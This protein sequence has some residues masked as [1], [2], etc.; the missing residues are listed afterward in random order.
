MHIAICDDNV[1]DRKQ[2]ERLL[3][4]ESDSRKHDTGVFYTDSYG[5]GFK[6]LPR[7]MSYDLFFLSPTED[8]PD[9]I[10]FAESLRNQ[11]VTAPIAIV[12]NDNMRDLIPNIEASDDF[13][14]INKPILK[15]DLSALLDKAIDLKENQISTIELRTR[16]TTF[17]VYEDDIMYATSKGQYVNVYLSDGKV[18]EVLDTMSNLYANISMYTHYVS[19]SERSL[20]NFVY[21]EKKTG[22]FVFL[23]NGVRLRCDLIGMREYKVRYEEFKSEF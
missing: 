12:T 22:P 4:R 15:A 7:R 13:L 17:Y 1:A 20:A 19:L 3:G 23:K 14:Y 18:L 16:E 8:E 2:L 11:G 6:I 21:I 9:C 5:Q 10:S